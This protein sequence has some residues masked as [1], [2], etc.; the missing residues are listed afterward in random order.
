MDE[1]DR[2]LSNAARAASPGRYQ[3]RGSHEIERVLSAS[4][5]S[6]T[7]TSS[8]REPY[9]R[10]TGIS[11]VSTQNDLE[12]HP[13]ALSRIATQRS[14]HSN[15]VGRSI[16]SRES[17]KPLPNFGAGKPYP[18]HLPD[19]E[20]YVVEFDGPSDPLH[21]QNWPMKKKMITAV[22]LAYTTLTSA[23]GSSIFSAATAPISVQYNVSN[24][25]GILGVSFYV[26]GFA[27]GPTL[28]AP[29]SEL[30]GRRLPLVLS[31][32][33]FSLFSIAA[34]TGKDIQ[35]ILICRFFSGF[36][37]ACPLAVVAA[38]FSDMFDN[39]TRG[40]AVTVFSMAVF[41]GP[42]LA[43]F[44]GGFIVESYLGWRWTQ[45]LIS[46]MGFFAFFLDLFFLEE[47]YPPVILV[48]KASE[49]RRRTRNWGIHAKQEEIEVDLRELITKNFTRPMRLLFFEPIVTLLSIYMAFIYG[50]LYLFLT[51]YPFVFRGV[52]GFNAGE[53]GL[54][55]FGMV[56]GQLIA[57]TVVLLQQPW[58]LRKLKANN[59]VP[60]PE[61]RLPS[62]IVGGVFFA[63]GIFWFGWSGYRRDIHW[64]VPALSGLFTGFGLM[65]IFLQSLNYL[66]D[67]YLMFAASAI[68]GNTFLR[69][70]CGAGFPLF[71][72]QMFEGMGIEWA[73][74]LLGCI[75]VVLAPIPLIFWL[76]GHK[77]RAK[78]AYAPTFQAQAEEPVEPEDLP[79]AV[80]TQS[81]TAVNGTN[82]VN[83]GH[84]EEKQDDLAARANA[85]ATN[86][87]R[88]NAV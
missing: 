51:A 13:T 82:G 70:L 11:R 80:P 66:V 49:L 53:S 2:E 79:G 85:P 30:K 52:H 32:F 10:N 40:V 36:F 20:E 54:A 1:V 19:Q 84:E 16:K 42:L 4:T 73:S 46:I 25:V 26:L 88:S 44:V 34:A 41:T 29:L 12:R 7:S 21:A 68:A 78:S 61:W 55:F 64:I 67:S 65:S 24:E 38:V 31:M 50:I 86:G 81:Q 6:S 83:G 22:M 48:S 72:T 14:Q 62:V 28:W 43:P 75:A 5:T 77:I 74:T 45:Y 27:T 63:A 35:T 47:T 60:V 71:A 69:S 23:F 59:G 18:P 15:T 37:G 3:S 56:T 76:Y 9:R 58:Y 8:S 17:R 39:R 57:G 33:G 87:D